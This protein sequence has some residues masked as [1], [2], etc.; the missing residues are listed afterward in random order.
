MKNY[1][2]SFLIFIVLIICICFSI[3]YLD[4][5]CT[6]LKSTSENIENVIDEGDYGSSYNLSIKLM[7]DWQKYSD[8]ISIFT[9]HLE[10][11]NINSE[12]WKL[13][14]Y[15]KCRNRDES[16]ASIHNIKLMLKHIME[17]EN[18]NIK[19]VF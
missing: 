5:S 4:K 14:Q 16:L 19:N 1:I 8:V 17:L 18:V 15:T 2:V 9:D 11:D 7:D 3:N 10:I 12:I 13:T 6:K